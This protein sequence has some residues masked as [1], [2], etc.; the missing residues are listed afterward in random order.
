MQTR[1]GKKIKKTTRKRTSDAGFSLIEL[2]VVLGILALVATLS[3][4]YVLRYLGTAKSQTAKTQIANLVSAVELYYLDVSAYPN[5]SIGPSA[6][7]QAPPE[8]KG[9]NGPYIRQKTAIV[10]P[11][12][13]PYVYRLPGKNGAFD[14]YSLGRD[15]K[16]D[17]TGEDAD[18]TSW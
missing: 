9:W 2:L 13:R 4:P 16:P 1:V 6:L 12:Q 17:G 8:V 5:Q 11:W 18:V 7:L 3:A 15:G 14:I 10:D